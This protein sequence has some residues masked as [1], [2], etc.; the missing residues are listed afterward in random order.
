MIDYSVIVPVHNLAPW[1]PTC[2]E[3]VYEAA[4]G[5]GVSVECIVVD[6]GSTDGSGKLIDELAGRYGTNGFHVQTLHHEK[7][8]GASAA[9]NSALEVARGEWICF[10]DGDDLLTSDSFLIREKCVRECPKAD[11]LQFGIVYVDEQAAENLA[12]LNPEPLVATIIKDRSEILGGYSGKSFVTYA[13]RRE[14]MGRIRFQPLVLGE[15][16]LFLASCL[17]CAEVKVCTNAV[18]YVCRRRQGSAFRSPMTVRKIHDSCAY[19]QGV[20]DVIHQSG[21]PVAIN[22]RRRLLSGAIEG[23]AGEVLRLAPVH[24]KDGWHEWFSSLAKI[25]DYAVTSLWFRGVLGFLRRC[26]SP[27]FAYLLCVLPLKLKKS[28]LRR[29]R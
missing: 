16:R 6:D 9:R 1:L 17:A 11:V 4:R 26:H 3:S 22:V 10:V 5:A 8:Q 29:K 18:G 23:T 20:M 15:D 2:L 14:R 24:R 25:P 28:G 27:F 19:R 13:Y 12:G 7:N 21:V